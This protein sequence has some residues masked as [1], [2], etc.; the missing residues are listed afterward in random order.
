M[1]VLIVGLPDDAP[2]KLIHDKVTARGQQAVYFDTTTF[3]QQV[4]MTFD[5]EKPCSGYFTDLETKTKTPLEEIKSVYRR[6]SNG[7][8][9]PKET[10]PMLQEVIY[11]NLESAVGSFCRNLDCLWV[12]TEEAT[13]LHKYKGKQLQMLTEAGV[14]IPKTIMTNDPEEVKAFYETNNK[15]VAVKPVRGWAHTEILK[16]ADLTPER[17]NALSRVPVKLQEFIE[18]TDIRA[19]LVK[20]E[21]FAM[22]IQAETTD[23]REDYEAKRVPITLPDNVLQDCKKLADTLGYLFTGIDLRRTPEG[24]YVFFEGNPTPMF[25]YD[26]QMTSYPVSDRLVDLLLSTH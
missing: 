24:E 13:Q 9:A 16:D 8:K 20:D 18:G 6:W 25:I 21:M 19:Y 12:N 14:R 11:W 3:P 1:T 17:L 26:E 4:A 5:P 2:S 23:F 15:H 7:V 10:D 22:E